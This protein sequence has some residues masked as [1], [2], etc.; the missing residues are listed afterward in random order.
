MNDVE[1]KSKVEDVWVEKI[2]KL[3]NEHKNSLKD[4][5]ESENVDVVTEVFIGGFPVKKVDIGKRQSIR[6]DVTQ[7]EIHEAELRSKL[8]DADIK[9]IGVFHESYLEPLMKK[10]FYRFSHL[11]HNGEVR[12]NVA[13]FIS[14]EY[15][16]SFGAQFVLA[17]IGCVVSSSI[18]ANILSKF[19]S[20]S[21]PEDLFIVSLICSVLIIVASLSWANH[22]GWTKIF[23]NKVYQI[24]L[25]LCNPVYSVIKYIDKAVYLSQWHIKKKVFVDNSD[26]SFASEAIKS[27]FKNGNKNND[28]YFVMY[29]KIKLAFPISTEE[30]ETVAQT[31]L[32]AYNANYKVEL[33]VHDH[34]FRI[35]LPELSKIRKEYWIAKKDPIHFVR[36]G[37]MIAI[38]SHYGSNPY[39]QDIID[40]VKTEFNKLSSENLRQKIG[41]N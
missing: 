25:W 17:T 40:Y 20:G 19:I 8:A 23:A 16:L 13:D 11:T 4:S 26:S 12:V 3:Y 18:Y 41:L 21:K 39:E 2:E 24:C 10:G 29:G 31:L 37:K 14:G 34:S 7:N 30:G 38:I 1:L 28:K 33:L 6:N 5:L 27:S 22:D 35:E 15:F 36:H 9:P 32:K